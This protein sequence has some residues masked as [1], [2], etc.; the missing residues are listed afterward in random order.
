MN[1]ISLTC[2]FLLQFLV[3]FSQDSI[4]T[5]ARSGSVEQ[6]KELLKTNPNCINEKN[7]EGYTPLILAC[8]RSNNE[9]ATFFIDNGAVLDENSPMGSALMASIVKGNNEIV[10]LLLKKN[11]DINA[12]D[13]QGITPLIYAVQFKNT[14]VIKWLLSYNVDKNKVDS[15]GKTAFEYAVFSG[16]EEIINLLK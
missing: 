10:S 3:S 7:V 12:S 15:K 2:L 8:Y 6:V 13:S 5:I 14:E 1:K 9:V 16:N 4:F 11:A